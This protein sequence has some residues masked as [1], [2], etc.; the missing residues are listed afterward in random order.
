MLFILMIFIEIKM[1]KPM[2]MMVAQVINGI[3]ALQEIIGATIISSNTP[4]PQMTEPFGI[5]HMRLMGM[6][7]KYIFALQL[8]LF[9]TIH[10]ISVVSG[11]ELIHVTGFH[12]IDSLLM[13]RLDIFLDIIWHMVLP[14]FC[15]AFV[16]LASITRQT[17][18]S[19]LEVLELDYIRSARAKGCKEKDVINKHALK[20]AMIPTITIIGI[21]IGGLLGGAV[22]TETTFAL[23]GFG[24]LMID[25]IQNRDYFVI[26]ALLFVDVIAYSEYLKTKSISDLYIKKI[27]ASIETISLNVLN[28]KISKTEYDES[29]IKLF[30]S[31]LRYQNNLHLSHKD[32][33]SHIKTQLEKYYILDIASMATWGDKTID[34]DEQEFLFQ[35]GKDLMSFLQFVYSY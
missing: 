21:R 22:L 3:M 14:V 7:L 19:M 13:G 23:D 26:N 30:E 5:L 11:S 2:K 25:A 6:V 8:N 33:V 4:M 27:E 28:S 32:A 12:M 17:R 18:S 31:S 24:S 15:L 20:N 10:E 35:L 9:P 16:G 34:K 29:L 1:L